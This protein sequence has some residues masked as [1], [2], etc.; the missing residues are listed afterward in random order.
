MYDSSTLHRL[1]LQP[2]HPRPLLIQSHNVI[3]RSR[4]ALI[5]PIYPGLAV[6]RFFDRLKHFFI[7][8]VWI[9]F[10]GAQGRD[11][12]SVPNQFFELVY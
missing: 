5:Q 12:R 3:L 9:K 6:T 1:C 2:H 11:T 8:P 10:L 4:P 7:V